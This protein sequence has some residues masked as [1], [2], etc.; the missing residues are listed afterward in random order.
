MSQKLSTQTTPSPDT[1]RSMKYRKV[2]FGDTIDTVKIVGVTY[3]TDYTGTDFA[4]LNKALAPSIVADAAQT[5]LA[6]T[7]M[8]EAINVMVHPGTDDEFYAELYME[9]L[10]DWSFVD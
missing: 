8:V 9:D 7:G 10:G 5:G 1:Y 6:Y 4:D 3:N 2:K